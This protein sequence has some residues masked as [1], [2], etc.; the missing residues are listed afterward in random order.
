MPTYTT[1]PESTLTEQLTDT[2]GGYNHN[3]K[4]GDGEFYDMK[5]LTSDYYP[6]M[7]NRAARSLIQS[8]VFTYIGGM[9]VD[10][11]GDLYI[12]GNKSGG[13][14]SS[15]RLYKIYKSYSA[16]E[17]DYS[18]L[19]D[20]TAITYD[21]YADLGKLL[22]SGKVQLIL[23]NDDLVIFPTG[24][25]VK[26]KKNADGHYYSNHLSMYSQVVMTSA[27]LPYVKISPCDSDGKIITSGTSTYVRITIATNGNDIYSSYVF[28]A[29]DAV[30]ISTTINNKEDTIGIEG[31]HIIVKSWVEGNNTEHVI[32]GTI[33]ATQTIDSSGSIFY[34]GRDVPDMDLV[35]QA[36]NRLWGCHYRK[37]DSANM[38]GINEIYACKLGDATNWN[39]FQGISTDSYKASCGTPG[40][41]T[42]AAN[43]NGYPI[44]FKENYFHKVFVSPTGAHQI[45]D[46]VIDGVQDG[47][48]GSVAMVGN[49]CYYKSRNGVVAFDGSTTYST[50]DNLGDE[51]YTDAVGGSANGKYYISMKNSSG[52]WAMFA[53]DA[54]KGLWHKEDESHAVQFCS[55]NGDTLYVTQE[56]TDSYDIHLISDYNKTSAQESVPEWEAV[57]GLQ[58]Y[59]YTG[60]KYIS[61]FNMRMMLPKGSYMD[62]YIEYDSSGKWEHQG[63]IKGTGTTSFMIP[64]RPR[65][66]DHFRIKLTGSGEVRLYS[67]SK[68][69][70]GG[71]DIR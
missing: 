26:T 9:A 8:G 47:C 40:K 25:K 30:R 68:L 33:S 14:Y 2:F 57:T 35:I 62:I 58:G 13:Q 69:F 41:F 4:I 19:E 45:Q 51:R 65:R 46:K 61:R 11:N 32:A 16:D 39:V 67:M 22:F 6:L 23:F 1:I 12:V 48:S 24:I 56:S 66:C 71:T 21:D 54:A 53:Y 15:E 17:P 10:S 70:E 59:S 50:G 64:V 52:Q 37:S 34:M 29:G 44:F 27:S 20:M 38:K 42:G 63:H 49:I 3:L 55:V 7:G 18:T 5:N 28:P 31:T 60:Q 43:V 36:Q